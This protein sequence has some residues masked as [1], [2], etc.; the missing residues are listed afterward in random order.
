MEAAAFA[1]WVAVGVVCVL[2]L[3]ARIRQVLLRA[4]TASL[5]DLGEYKY[6]QVRQTV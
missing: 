1:G 3:G 6:S 2:C 5:R 4:H